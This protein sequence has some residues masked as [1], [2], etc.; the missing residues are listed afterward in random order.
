MKAIR[1]VARVALSCVR[2]HHPAEHAGPTRILHGDIAQTEPEFSWSRGRH[3]RVASG[4]PVRVARRV[5]AWRGYF[6]GSK[7]MLATI[8]ETSLRLPANRDG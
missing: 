2:R 4:C 6:Q 7:S 5:C 3:H 8:D 1:I